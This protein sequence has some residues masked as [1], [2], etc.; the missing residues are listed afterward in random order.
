MADSIQERIV[1][2]IVAALGTITV[3]NGYS[4][5]IG[6]V[7]RYHASGV[8]INVAVPA[9]LVKEGECSVE[10]ALSVYPSIQRRMQVEVTPFTSHDEVADTR[11]G[12]EIL[13]SL[14]A[15]V[16]RC[17]ATNRT[18]DGLAIQTDP[19]QYFETEL[20]AEEPYLSKGLQFDVVYQH[21]RTD[22]YAQA[23]SA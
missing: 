13:N 8:R 9:I 21:L 22:P 5:T 12:A 17:V 2:K 20:N 10:L 11:S 7:Q 14:V 18:W 1:K 4:N 16:E 23:G 19:P 15:D 6:S 3:A